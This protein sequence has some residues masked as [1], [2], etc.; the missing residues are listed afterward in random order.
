MKIQNFA[1]VLLYL[2]YYENLIQKLLMSLVLSEAN[3][4]TSFALTPL[5][6]EYIDTFDGILFR[7]PRELNPMTSIYEQTCPGI[8][9]E[10]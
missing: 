9:V 1:V 4:A 2:I 6:R 10:T 3:P 5:F 7:V 8:D